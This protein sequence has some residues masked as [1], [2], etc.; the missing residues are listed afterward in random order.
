MN[1]DPVHNDWHPVCSVAALA[2]GRPIAVQLL[3]QDIVVWRSG[4][5]LCAWR[6]RCVHRGTKLSLGNV[7]PDGTLQCPYHGWIYDH[8][9][10]CVHIPAMPEHTPPERACV[11]R[12]RVE[13]RYGV[14][15]VCL[16]EPVTRAPFPEWDDAQFRKIACGPYPVHT[17][18]PRIIENFLDVSHFAFVH[19]NILGVRG[20]AQ[21]DE[22]D[23]T[24]GQEGLEASN[25]RVYQP[26]P[27]GTGQG[28]TVA[29]IYRVQ[30]PFS[31]YLRKESAGP[32]FS[33]LLSVTPH[34]PVES[35][36]WM[37]MAMNY[38]ED[39]PEQELIDWQDAI[40]AQD[41]PIVESQ[42][43]ALLPLDPKAEL[44]MRCDRMAVEYRRWLKGVGL[45][46]G[47]C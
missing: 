3:E 40:F 46:F 22:Y 18:A 30:R 21:V 19:E 35:T 38:G 11:P 7:L 10:Q 31:A 17:S 28:D 33:I 25:V 16:G 12:F 6:D 4:E 47:V 20:H 29:Y 1:L 44:S 23:V 34:T 32:K 45:T 37:W 15:W 5:Q 27:Y 2:G 9:G 42:L 36:A 24:C 39:I 26:D 43:P 8:R 14:V 13:Q 41:R